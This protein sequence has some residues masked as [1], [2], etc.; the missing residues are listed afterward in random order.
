MSLLLLRPTEHRCIQT[1]KCQI[2]VCSRTKTVRL[3]CRHATALGTALLTPGCSPG[4]GRAS[5]VPLAVLGALA[6]EHS[7]RQCYGLRVVIPTLHKEN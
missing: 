5:Q 1:S 6:Q 3:P 2:N 7:S 4:T